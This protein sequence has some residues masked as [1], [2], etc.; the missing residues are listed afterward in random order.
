MKYRL[1]E[2]AR[3]GGPQELRLVERDLVAPAKGQVRLRVLASSVSLPDVDAR[4][5]RSPFP[6]RLPFTPGYSVVGEV[7]AVG[8]S[9]SPAHLGKRAGV[10]TVYGG[11]SEA[12]YAPVKKLIPVPADLKAERLVPLILNYIVAYQTLRRTAGVRGGD[13]V[14]FIGASGGIGTAYLQLGKSLGCCMY[15]LASKRKHAALRSYGATLIDYHSQDFAAEIRRLEPDGLDAVFDGVGGDYLARGYGLLRR[16]GT[17]VGY[18]NPGSLGGMFRL[19]A[20]VVGCNLRMDG[21]RVKL[22]GTGQSYLD[23]RPFQK[24]WA[25]L[26]DLLRADKID[27]VIAARF[28]LREARQA[29]EL[30]ES[31]EVVGN[32]VLLAT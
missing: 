12:V 16:G 30:L 32:I 23:A 14:L 1:F 24:D 19:L 4:Y 25:D 11:Y 26:I 3:R 21:R 27:P 8:E 13:R 5:G 2:V 20:D 9:V 6:P 31:G 17:W 29:N 28:P 10:L 18:A 7:D 22:Y 15:G